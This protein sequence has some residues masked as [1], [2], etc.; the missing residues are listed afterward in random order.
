MTNWSTIDVLLNLSL[1]CDT[2]GDSLP[3][4]CFTGFSASSSGVVGGS[5]GL[6]NR[7]QNK[8]IRKYV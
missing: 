5:L 7:K 2:Y 3:S 4:C 8:V 1:T 6:L